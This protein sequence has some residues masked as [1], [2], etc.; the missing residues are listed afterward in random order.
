MLRSN[1][2]DFYKGMLIFLVSIGHAVQCAAY[3]EEGFFQDPTFKAIYMFHMP[4]FIAI[5][6]YVSRNSVLR[7]PPLEFIKSKIFSLLVPIAIWE[8]L[9]RVALTLVFKKKIDQDFPLSLLLS[10]L[11]SLW[12]LWALF[13]SLVLVTIANVFG[14]YSFWV[15]LI[16][17]FFSLFIPDWGILPLIKY[18]CPFFLAGY[19]LAAGS[20]VEKLMPYKNVIFPV[21]GVLALICFFLWNNQTYIYVTGMELSSENFQNIALRYIAGAIA[22]VF[23]LC[24]FYVAYL[25]LGERIIQGFIIFGKNSLYIYII[26]QYAFIGVT[27]ISV[28]YFEPVAFA[29]L[30]TLV[31]FS[32]GLLVT[33]ICCATGVLLAKNKIAAK[34]LFGKVSTPAP[35]V[36]TIA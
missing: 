29:P 21:S 10:I 23:A 32:I 22:S 34:L 28:R 8:I 26:G 14:R 15:S 5:S 35:T 19:Y 16:L 18:T 1:C 11:Q 33:C 27:K 24:V 25:K 2:V 31:G 13:A 36:A 9:F 17:F 20:Y 3:Q 6:G 7:T 4:L 30:A 12:F